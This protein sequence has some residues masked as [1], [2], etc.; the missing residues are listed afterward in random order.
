M[1]HTTYTSRTGSPPSNLKPAPL[2][3]PLRKAAASLDDNPVTVAAQ[4]RGGHGDTPASAS[5]RK[6]A[7][8]QPHPDNITRALPHRRELN[9]KLESLVSRF[10]T[11]DAAN[12]ADTSVPQYPNKSYEPRVAGSKQN[13][14]HMSTNYLPVKSLLNRDSSERSPRQ[15]V[16]NASLRRKSMLPV[17]TQLLAPVPVRAL[18]H[19]DGNRDS[20]CPKVPDDRGV[21]MDEQQ[22]SPPSLLTGQRLAWNPAHIA[23]RLK[24]FEQNSCKW[25]GRCVLES[26]SGIY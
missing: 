4:H 23:D 21:D 18:D 8:H 20:T 16:P 1:S 14:Q 15:I 13:P 19:S 2:R 26:V 6:Y 25:G 12:S 9:S 5:R 17:S 10:E 24:P 7:S 3:I 11:L 22:T